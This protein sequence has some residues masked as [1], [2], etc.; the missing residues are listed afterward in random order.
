M[1][2]RV[3]IG[4]SLFLIFIG[5]VVV[6]GAIRLGLGTTEQLRP[7]FLPFLC[8]VTLVGLS[9]VLLFKAW[10]GRTVKSQPFG[11]WRRPIAVLAG[12]VVY[13]IV[14]ERLGYVISTAFLSVILLRVFDMKSKWVLVAA[15]LGI[16]VGTYVLFNSLLGVEL[17][18]GVIRIHGR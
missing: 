12:L 9:A 5:T 8:G 2:N 13:V 10:Q 17:P 11:Q 1:R 6:I 15:S 18:S 3:D 16:A 7:G 14:F 4:A